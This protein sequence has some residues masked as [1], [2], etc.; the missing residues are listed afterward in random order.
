[1]AAESVRR[2]AN[3]LILPF[4]VTRYATV[5]QAEFIDFQNE[6]Q[7]VLDSLNIKLDHLK[8]SLD[9]FKDVAEKFH[10]RLAQSDK[11]MYHLIRMFNDQLRR[12]ENAFLDPSGRDRKG[13][14]HLVHGPSVSD[15]AGGDIFPSVTDAIYE[16]RK[17]SSS[18]EL[19]KKIEFNLSIVT[20]AIRSVI[21][22]LKDPTDFTRF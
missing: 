10:E 21:S 7:D 14:E 12:V 16:Y 9:S 1:M 22:V 11:T 6:Y 2:L 15:A 20:Y 13:Y 18:K 5:L 8:H 3:S 17:N 4:N 19:P